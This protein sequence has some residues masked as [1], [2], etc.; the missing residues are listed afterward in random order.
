MIP[1]SASVICDIV[2]QSE[3]SRDFVMLSED[4][5]NQTLSVKKC[6]KI[7]FSVATNIVR[8]HLEMGNHL[9]KMLLM[10][11]FFNTLN[12]TNDQI[13]RQCI[14]KITGCIE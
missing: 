8:I 2:T 13:S 7:Y 14:S 5:H 9:K 1:I 3:K 11:K 12:S 6:H 10:S 4:L